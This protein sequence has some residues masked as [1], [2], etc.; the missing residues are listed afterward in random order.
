MDFD[1]MKTNVACHR[2][3][4]AKNEAS[5]ETEAASKPNVLFSAMIIGEKMGKSCID[6]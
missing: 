1:I 3:V 4:T 6:L 2:L 5:S